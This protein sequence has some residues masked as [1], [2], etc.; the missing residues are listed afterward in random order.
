MGACSCWLRRWSIGIAAG[1]GGGWEPDEEMG[2]EGE[3]AHHSSACQKVAVE[4]G[5]EEGE[6]EGRS[7]LEEEDEEEDEPMRLFRLSAKAK[8]KCP[9]K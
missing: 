6:D 5:R 1:K 9:M 4:E 7:K 8:G 2:K 3:E